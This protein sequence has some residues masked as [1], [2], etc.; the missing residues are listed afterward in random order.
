MRRSKTQQISKVIQDFLKESGL[1]SRLKEV[2]LINSWEEIVG[3]MISKRTKKVEIK[4]GKMIIYLRSSVVK[5]ELM[6]LRES[7][8]NSLNE[9]AGEEIIK[10][11]IL[12]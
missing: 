10:E 9:K 2:E 4:N 5:N 11:I 1:E 6:M 7:L 8:R 3:T 12:K